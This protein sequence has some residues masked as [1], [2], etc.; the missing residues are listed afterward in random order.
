MDEEPSERRPLT[1]TEQQLTAAHPA[2]NAD[3]GSH[4]GT[5]PTAGGGGTGAVA[6]GGDRR[7][8]KRGA[9]MDQQGD[10]DD[11]RREENEQCEE[12]EQ[13]GGREGT[14]GGA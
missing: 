10:E 4:E 7:G 2:A 1:P 13:R 9:T 8:H 5:A 6:E 12:N 3:S 11:G 14:D